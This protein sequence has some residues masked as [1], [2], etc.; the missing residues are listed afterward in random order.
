MRVAPCPALAT[1]TYP[2]LLPKAGLQWYPP[3][4]RAPSS[5]ATRLVPSEAPTDAVPS[6]SSAVRVAAAR[7]PPSAGLRLL[8]V[9]SHIIPGQRLLPLHPWL[10]LV[11]PASASAPSTAAR[12]CLRWHPLA[13]RL[14]PQHR[15][16]LWGTRHGVVTADQRSPALHHGCLW[17]PQTLPHMLPYHRGCLW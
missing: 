4:F 15:L 13:E 12:G 6:S 16:C 11:A 2:R 9:A 7:A 14:L 5:A 17:W 8:L 10:A 1:S 3:T